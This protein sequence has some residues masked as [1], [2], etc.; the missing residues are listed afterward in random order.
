MCA[1]TFDL[2]LARRLKEA[3]NQAG[4]LLK[5][6]ARKVGFESYQVLSYI[7]KGTRPVKAWELAKLARIYGHNVADLLE[8]ELPSRETKVLWRERKNSRAVRNHEQRFLR[9]L[10]NYARLERMAG[11]SPPRFSPPH[12][13][14]RPKS[15]EEVRESGVSYAGQLCLGSR[16]GRVLAQV[17]EE[18][19]GVKIIYQDMKDSGSAA[20]VWSEEFGPAICLNSRDVPWRRN[21][22]IAHELFHLVTWNLYNPS[23]VH[24][25]GG[26]RSLVEKYANAFAS[27]LLLPADALTL[28]FSRRVV[29]RRI[30][31]FDLVALAREFAV[32]TQA[33]LAACEHSGLLTKKAAQEALQSPD[34]K[35]I[36]RQERQSDWQNPPKASRRFVELA[37]RALQRGMVSRGRFAEY[38]GI[39]R[40]EIPAFLARY[41]FAEEGYESEIPTAR[42]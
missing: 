11:V 12:I 40:S 32:S 20:S 3:R 8:E 14:V 23:E 4:L 42:C 36:N 1:D 34:I 22:D 2:K 27:A 18:N 39:N 17:L 19:Q 31:A 24:P 15:W 5:E 35:R 28:E 29:K 38:F 30:S 33:L 21:Y 41:G 26:G 16:P 13:P 10:K 9:A 6:V 37:L 7:E 25:P